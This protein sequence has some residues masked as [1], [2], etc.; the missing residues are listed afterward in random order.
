MS[1]PI[2][3]DPESP[4]VQIRRDG[5]LRIDPFARSPPKRDASKS[6]ISPPKREFSKSRLSPPKRE[7]SVRASVRA[8]GSSNLL[9]AFE[10][11]EQQYYDPEKARQAMS[12]RATSGKI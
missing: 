8:D 1:F 11:N 10:E 5:S 3:S 7:A 4:A 12:R 6:S 9:L 2:T